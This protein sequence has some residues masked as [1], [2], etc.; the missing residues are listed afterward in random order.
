MIRAIR[1]L[2]LSS[3]TVDPFTLL[4][5]SPTDTSP[6]TASAFWILMMSAGAMNEFRLA[7]S[8]SDP[9]VPGRAAAVAGTRCI[10]NVGCSK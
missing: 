9:Y 5:A 1:P 2:K 10:P 8:G 4:T 3:E 6:C 7:C